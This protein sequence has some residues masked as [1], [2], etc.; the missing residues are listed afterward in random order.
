MTKS[1]LASRLQRLSS[2]LFVKLRE[3]GSNE[4]EWFPCLDRYF[5]SNFSMLGFCLSE[6]NGYHQRKL[7]TNEQFEDFQ[8]DSSMTDWEILKLRKTKAN[9]LWDLRPNYVCEDYAK[10]YG[11]AK[12]T[13]WPTSKWL[14][15]ESDSFRQVEFDKRPV[16]LV[17]LIKST[18]VTQTIGK[19]ASENADALNR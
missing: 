9:E 8:L 19:P 15:R 4:M 10:M 1:Q 11:L 3:D 5:Q 6:P 17:T 2:A 16:E 14:L 18:V 7:W 13:L 12:S